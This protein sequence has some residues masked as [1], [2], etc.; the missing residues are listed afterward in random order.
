[1]M[2][3]TDRMV[4][5]SS[6]FHGNPNLKLWRL[7]AS[8]DGDFDFTATRGM[9]LA[10]NTRLHLMPD[11]TFSVWAFGMR[12]HLP[13]DTP[14]PHLDRISSKTDLHNLL[15]YMSDMRPCYGVLDANDTASYT[16][17]LVSEA[18]PVK[19]S[20]WFPVA[21]QHSCHWRTHSKG[22]HL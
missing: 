9:H 6:D 13:S 20:I 22:A 14:I 2:A 7:E 4:A 16:E 5:I 18:C 12:V 10:N 17:A 15:I 11:L 21:S 8:A 1:M 3:S 19:R